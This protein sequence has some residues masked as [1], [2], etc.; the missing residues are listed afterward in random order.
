MIPILTGTIAIYCLI[1]L[2]LI[3]GFLKILPQR[4]SKTIQ[5]TTFSICISFRNEAENLPVLLN[6][7]KGLNYPD[8]LTEIILVDDHSTDNSVEIITKFCQ[9]NAVFQP[10]MTFLSQKSTAKSG[11]KAALSLAVQHA[12]NDYI[13]T[14]D[15]DCIVPQDWLREFNAFIINRK[16]KFIAAPVMLFETS[17]SFLNLFQ[18]L[19]F[20]SLQGATMGAFGIK[21]P[22][23][24][25][26]ANLAFC[27]SNFFRLGGY[28]GNEDIASGDDLFMMQ[29]FLED[30]PD[31]VGYLKSKNSVVKTQAQT[32]WHQLI[33]Q[34]KRWAAKA[35]KYKNSVA[36]LVSWAV[37]L[38]NFAFILAIFYLNTS[39][40][41]ISIVLFKILIDFLLI[42]LAASFFGKKGY[43]FGYLVSFLIYPF[44]TLYIAV[45]SQLHPFDW[46]GRSLKK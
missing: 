7:L 46:K 16:K 4:T 27:R 40:F 18:Q 25:N 42:A 32:S 28:T 3:V 44:F 8:Q 5:K 39:V 11:K 33:N 23:L 9:E 36:T 14:T 38:A 1:I 30:D 22:F 26:G 21:K 12:K 43:L 34:R 15:A 6:S 2:I 37:F 41:L 13:V 20:L 45:S 17:S 31:S 29:K 24:C 10:K 19:D 35:S